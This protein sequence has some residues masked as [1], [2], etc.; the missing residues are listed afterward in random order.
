M[1]YCCTL[2]I[3]TTAPCNRVYCRPTTFVRVKG[4]SGILNSAGASINPLTF[5]RRALKGF[6]YMENILYAL[7]MVCK[8][9]GY[10]DSKFPCKRNP[11]RAFLRKVRGLM[12]A[13]A[14]FKIPEI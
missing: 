7:M 6:V 2:Y 9:V 13:P 1:I 14:Q 5:L 4:I 8:I 3:E 12:L 11:F 10:L